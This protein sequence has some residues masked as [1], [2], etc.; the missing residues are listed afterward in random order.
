ML[1]LC[2]SPA[3]LHSLSK[4]ISKLKKKK[5]SKSLKKKKKVV[6]RGMDLEAWGFPK[7]PQGTRTRRH[8][9]S[10]TDQE[11]LRGRLEVPR[12]G[13]KDVGVGR[14]GIRGQDFQ[15]SSGVA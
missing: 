8:W 5:D 11:R 9:G 1:S 2:P 10:G 12:A 13:E 3:H 15:F 6:C 7:E 14:G 4:Y